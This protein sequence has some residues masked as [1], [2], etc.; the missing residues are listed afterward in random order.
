VTHLQGEEGPRFT[1]KNQRIRL[2]QMHAIYDELVQ[3]NLEPGVPFLVC[4][5]FGTP[6]F[7]EDGAAETE[8]YRQML[9]TFGV[10]N[11]ADARITLD[12][13]PGGNTLAFPGTGRKN[14]LDYILL[15]SN[16]AR[17]SVQ[18]ER[19]VLQCAGWDDP[20]TARTDLSYRYAV[21]ASVAFGGA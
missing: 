6:R 13:S 12:E 17:V 2:R 14:E 4:G 1:E 21:G 16:G 15:R 7:A 3:P 9:A 20:V 10:E 8:P 5:D 18:R 19:R 11:G